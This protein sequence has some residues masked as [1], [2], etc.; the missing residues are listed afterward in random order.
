[1]KCLEKTVERRYQSMGHLADDLQRFMD[2]GQVY[3]LSE[4]SSS[5]PQ[6]R[7]VKE[8][9]ESLQNDSSTRST[10]LQEVGSRTKSWWKFWK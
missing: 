5:D 4:T 8:G 3:A 2:G 10:T 6:L 9:R 7:F 1:M